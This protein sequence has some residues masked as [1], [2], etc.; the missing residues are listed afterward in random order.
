M[1]EFRKIAGLNV[2]K[3]IILTVYQKQSKKMKNILILYTGKKKEIQL[4][5][6]IHS[7]Y[8]P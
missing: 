1:R 6:V 7:N 5:L 4:I 3:L 8:V 2:V